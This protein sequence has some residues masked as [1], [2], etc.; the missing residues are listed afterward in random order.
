MN[1]SLHDV[2]FVTV[3][4]VCLFAFP[5]QYEQ[6]FRG[7]MRSKNVE[8][9]AKLREKAGDYAGAI[10]LYINFNYRIDALA[11]AAAYESKGIVL[12]RDV[13]VAFLAHTFAKIYCR[14]KDKTKLLKVLGYMSDASQ[15]TR[16]L[17]EANLFSKAVEVHIQ[18]GQYTEAYRILTAQARHKEGI[19]LAEKQGDESMMVRF[20][21]QK[22]VS[23]LLSDGS[24]NDPD[25]VDRLQHIAVGKN[26]DLKAQACLLLGRSKKDSAMCRKALDLYKSS[27]PSHG[28]GEVESFNAF[29]E[30]KPQ[31]DKP[32]QL[33][34]PLIEACKAAKSV[35]KAIESRNK[36]TI[37][38]SYRHILEEVEDFY[39]LQK[40]GESD[41]YIFPKSQDLWAKLVECSTTSSELDPDGMLKLDAKLTLQTISERLN[42]CLTEWME[43]DSLSVCQ[44]LKTRLSYFPFHK[45][46]CEGGFLQQSFTNYPLKDYISFCLLALDTVHCGGK[47]FTS[48]TITQILQNLFSPQAAVH[49][50]VGKF[51]RDT[52]RRSELACKELEAVTTTTLR[53]Q[54]DKFKMDEWLEAWRIYSMLGKGTQRMESVLSESQ[55]QVN[56]KAA[57]VQKAPRH[58]AV[59][60]SHK[61]AA[62]RQQPTHG[63]QDEYSRSDR[64]EFKPPH[65]FVYYARED[66]YD[67]IFSLFLKSCAFIRSHCKVLTASKLV[68]HFIM[69]KILAS[70]ISVTNLVNIAC[71]HSIA[72]LGLATHCY[73]LLKQ[74]SKFLVPHTYRHIAQ[75]FD[76]L[77][78]QSPGDKWLLHACMEDVIVQKCSKPNLPQLTNDIL[79]LLQLILNVLIGRHNQ[80]FNV[81]RYA[82]KN[83]RCLQNGEAKHCLILVLTLF[84]NLAA[85]NF[86]SDQQLHDYQMV[87]HAALEHLPNREVLHTLRQVQNIF[88]SSSNVS[89]SF[90]ALSQL[91]ASTDRSAHLLRFTVV[92]KQRTAKLEFAPLLLQQLPQRSMTSVHQQLQKAPP[93][94]PLPPPSPSANSPQPPIKFLQGEPRSSKN[95]SST[96]L[97][98]LQKL[99]PEAPSQS[100]PGST[101]VQS[102]PGSTPMQSP[103][104]SAHVQSPPGSTHVQS[105]PGSTHVQSPPGSTHVHSPPGSTPVQS[106]SGS[107][108][109]PGSTPVQ[110]PPGSTHVQSPPGSTHVQSPPGSTH[111][112]SP[113]GSTH[114]HSPP[115]STP[116]QSP[117]GSIPPPGSTPVQSPPGSTHVQ[118]PPGST[119]VQPL[120]SPQQLQSPHQTFSQAVQASFDWRQVP[121]AQ[122]HPL[123]AHSSVVGSSHEEQ[124]TAGSSPL[125]QQQHAVIAP[126]MPQTLRSMSYPE[127]E[128]EEQDEQESEI[129]PN[130]DDEDIREAFASEVTV[131]ESQQFGESWI[132]EATA[133]GGGDKSDHSMIDENLCRYCGVPLRQ[134]K[135]AQS[136]VENWEDD[137]LESEEVERDGKLAESV[138]VDISVETYQDHV[139]SDHHKTQERLY[140]EFSQE[141]NDWQYSQL[142]SE[143]KNILADS[144]DFDEATNERDLDLV[145]TD[146]NVE[147]DRNEKRIE[148]IR[149]SCE[150]RSGLWDVQNVM[151]NRM[152]SLTDR[153]RQEQK[154]TEQRIQQAQ[155]EQLLKEEPEDQQQEDAY[156][157]P[158][159][160]EPAGL[161]SME[162]E[163]TR[164]R[165][166]KRGHKKIKK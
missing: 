116:V 109:P 127:P 10:K 2:L 146:I 75:V 12:P 24:L 74:P 114:V 119:P 149:R 1:A 121:V 34:R 82:I 44:A 86:W 161:V 8:G 28:I 50:P 41:V 159:E 125:Q 23:E 123:T 30:L 140:T 145:L 17:K 66:S 104:G 120:P 16:F 73:F 4:I 67:H 37:T 25:T 62:L 122:A 108:P 128:G 132:T 90:L 142:R 18:Q 85:S 32:L 150:W 151:V 95:E 53:T 154:R 101:H 7:F 56:I 84:G 153:G 65:V 15:R 9:C 112:Q 137:L 54:E 63:I 52:I 110:S 83:E 160:L 57:N 105:P 152:K 133:I 158:E 31:L 13:S 36:P 91:L 103:P 162:E 3:I 135:A 55:K 164:K 166:M 76:D 143:L 19:K 147:L 111:V 102:P 155:K 106:P 6:A 124:A 144:K 49:L 22:A 78:C 72:L 46:L 100:P 93:F 113:P 71:I 51:H 69:N 45:P 130:I 61:P 136:S 126:E 115:G 157:T 11:R 98:V 59:S 43:K 38:A 165:R 27:N 68:L 131:G 117:S 47:L 80:H 107:I 20:T 40:Q 97:G 14:Y 79:K 33:I 89:G 118:S 163:K 39:S 129:V 48:A 94:N 88:T 42:V 21:I 141:V 134:L 138:P 77:N 70:G 148:E 64:R 156:D 87:I 35:L 92:R 58:K 81:L 139:E 5:S 99:F 29:A 60:H 26:T 96:E